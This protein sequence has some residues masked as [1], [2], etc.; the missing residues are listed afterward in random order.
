MGFDHNTSIA[1]ITGIVAKEI[2]VATF[3]VLYSEG[4]TDE[5]S[6][7]LREKLRQ[8]IPPLTAVAFM[9][10]ALLYIP[11]MATIAVIYR[12]TA[13]LGWTAFS[14]GFSLCLG[15]SMAYMVQLVG[16]LFVS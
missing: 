1:L 16:G 7:S 8:S 5:E 10:F 13:S 4:E 15:W 3:G 9:V 2:V 11:C 14:I 6:L 12:E